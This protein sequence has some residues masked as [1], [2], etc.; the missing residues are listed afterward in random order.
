MCPL[1]DLEVLT[2]GEHFA[3]TRE[4]TRE[5]FLAC[6]YA[7]MI[8]QFILGLERTSTSRTAVPEAR[9]SRALGSADML[10]GQV[11]HN[12]V[13]GVEGFTARLARP[14]PV[15]PHAPHV[16]HGLHVPEERPRL[17]HVVG[18]RTLQGLVPLGSR[19]HDAGMVWLVVHGVRVVQTGPEPQ[20]VPGGRGCRKLLMV[21]PQQEVSGGVARV[22]VEVV[23]WHGVMIAGVGPL[24]EVVLRGLL[25]CGSH[26][27]SG[28][29]VVRRTHLQTESVVV[30]RFHKRVYH[31][32]A[33]MSSPTS[34]TTNLNHKTRCTSHNN[35]RDPQY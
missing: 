34:Q 20:H 21:S 35:T 12:L 30:R 2:P 26:H 25:H 16:L 5:G 22:M 18:V 28:P 8:H 7:D 6:M 3:T 32:V 27:L 13:H 14:G 4:R 33:P 29:R 9:V 31:S 1:V 23:S 19:V 11:R 15:Y 10:H 24:V 17:L